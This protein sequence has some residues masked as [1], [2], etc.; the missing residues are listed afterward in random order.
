MTLPVKQVNWTYNL[1]NRVAYTS[2]TQTSSEVMFL[3]KNTLTTAGYTVKGSSDGTVGAMDGVDRWTDATDA[4]TRGETPTDAASWIVLTDGNGADIL[5]AF[6]AGSDDAWSLA[7][8]HAGDYAAAETPTFK[9]LSANAQE[10]S[11]FF[12]PVRTLIGTQTASDRIVHLWLRPLAQGFRV[13]VMRAGRG[14]AAFGVDKH[15]PDSYAPGVTVSAGH[16]FYGYLTAMVGNNN[17]AIDPAPF[18]DGAFVTAV[19]TNQSTRLA[20]CAR[21]YEGIGGSL[22][23]SDAASLNQEWINGTQYVAELQGTGYMLRKIGL[24]STLAGS[25]G[26]VGMHD[27][28]WVGRTL[29]A[30]DG[31]TYGNREFIVVN[32]ATGLVWPWDGTPSV[33]G[34]PVTVS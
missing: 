18:L 32:A 10:L 8:S 33:A 7:V 30:F 22:N 34:S 5:F 16:G 31:D 4:A 11:S 21:L 1:N 14:V 26:R 6:V 23:N 19:R 27:D 25:R 17:A 12:A 9:P 28:W 2:L 15:T 13:M 20:T 24:W 29:G 3:I